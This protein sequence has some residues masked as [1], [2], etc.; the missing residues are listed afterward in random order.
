M[1]EAIKKFIKYLE[2]EKHYSKQTVSSYNFDLLG[3]NNYL[4][5]NELDFKYLTADDVQDYINFLKINKYKA[6]SINRKIVC[7]RSFYKFY[8]LRIDNTF[9]N[10]MINYK[11]IKQGK[12]LPHDLFVEQI[13]VI[14]TPNEKNPLLALRN[15]CIILLLLNTGMRVS[16][17]SNL[18]LLDVDL[19]GNAI[20]VFGKGH[21][22]RS[23]YYLPSLN[24]YLNDYLTNCRNVLLNNNKS[25]AF[26]ISSK[27]CRITTRAIENIL[28]DRAK[29]SSFYFKASPHMLRHTFATNLLNN[30]V[31][32]KIVQE[33]LGHSSLATTQIYTHVSKARLKKVYEDTHP[34]AKAI[35]EL[36]EK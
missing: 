20:R 26:F 2:N 36:K 19:I 3:F 5:E 10:I 32:L 15:Q 1:D 30:N 31:D 27:G 9:Q 28:N 11:T 14:L 35:N 16:E 8:C 6:S 34:V 23:V 33:L 12:R 18:N 7:L 24:S 25:E 21:K 29:Q 17:C 13:K 4:K 22:E